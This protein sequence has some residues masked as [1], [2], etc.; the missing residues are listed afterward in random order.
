VTPP[1]KFQSICRKPV[2][3]EKS[4]LK[5][6]EAPFP[7]LEICS[8][9]S[10]LYSGPNGDFTR[11]SFFGTPLRLVPRIFLAPPKQVVTSS[12]SIPVNSSQPSLLQEM[13][14]AIDSIDL[15]AQGLP[16]NGGKGGCRYSEVVQAKD[17]SKAQ[18]S[19]KF[20]KNTKAQLHLEVRP[21]QGKNFSE[22]HQLYVSYDKTPHRLGIAVGGFYLTHPLNPNDAGPLDTDQED[23]FE[24]GKNFRK[25]L[26]PRY[27]TKSSGEIP[28]S[29]KS[30]HLLMKPQGWLVEDAPG[31]TFDITKNTLLANGLWKENY[32]TDLGLEP[33]QFPRALNKLAALF[34]HADS[35]FAKLDGAPIKQPN[36]LHDLPPLVDWLAPEKLD[37]KVLFREKT[38]SLG[39]LGSIQF[40]KTDKNGVSIKADAKGTV[41]TV[42]L[43]DIPQLDLQLGKNHLRAKGLKAGKIVLN[44]PPIAE[45]T[46]ELGLLD[47]EKSAD[48][49]ARCLYPGAHPKPTK[50][51]SATFN[52]ILRGITIENVSAESISLENSDRPIQALLES[53]QIDSIAFSSAKEVQL[54]GLK[55]AKVTLKENSTGLATEIK[56]AVIA[57]VSLDGTKEGVLDLQAEGIE[58]AGGFQYQ[59]P[60]DAIEVQ[61][62]GASKISKFSL[63][64][65]H[66]VS[67]QDSIENELDF[68]GKID[69]LKLVHPSIGNLTMG[70]TVIG[71]STLKVAL[72]WQAGANTSIQSNFQLS[73][74]VPQAEVQ[75][76]H[77]QLVDIASS[78]LKKGKIKLESSPAGLKTEVSGNLD[79]KLKK[80]N[81]PLLDVILKGFTLEGSLEDIEIQGAGLLSLDP[82]AISLKKQAT[83]DASATL[84]ISGVL[85]GLTFSDDPSQRNSD[86]KKIPYGKAVKTQME[87]KDAKI[88]VGDLE[89]FEFIKG[90][91]DKTKK[92]NLK[93]LK[94]KNFSIG[95]IHAGGRIC[96]KFPIFGWLMGS[97]PEI[98]KATKI[99]PIQDTES[100][101]RFDEWDT[102]E[103]NGKKTTRLTNLLVQLFEIGGRNQLARF[104]LPLLTVQPG[105]IDTGKDPMELEVYLKDQDRGGDFQ[106]KLKDEDLSQRRR[107]KAP[108][109]KKDPEPPK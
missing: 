8:P 69:T 54:K 78:S 50:D 29:P 86:L 84:K 38:V 59:N 42:V 71:D 65:K 45:L 10:D 9:L 75:E 92:P 64:F 34:S 43:G 61:G 13:L 22:I 47:V 11:A 68:S 35:C 90:S 23:A 26:K 100:E 41:V 5:L 2:F 53:P 19:N 44:L 74:D 56:T 62:Q 83:D 107:R 66:D 89:A 51:R 96:A 98:G 18:C 55:S 27:Q 48:V 39:D 72:Q 79:L 21:V 14:L 57:K 70:N 12:S 73:L 1:F 108:P 81:I 40:G 60:K 106:F 52:K 95:E 4:E 97:F 49:I 93:T 99:L 30:S 109:P 102:H 67:G 32:Y 31:V 36:F 94:V 16:A 6:E 7:D 101:L 25:A 85:K 28:Y 58:S 46:K 103:E 82:Q 24:S 91:A 77:V 105:A 76:G 37:L 104:K 17:Y 63:R 80:I 20:D 87:L 3:F 88:G 15:D 33:F